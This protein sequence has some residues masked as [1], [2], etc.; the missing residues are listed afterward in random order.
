MNKNTVSTENSNTELQPDAQRKRHIHE[1]IDKK[2]GRWAKRGFAGG[3]GSTLLAL[4]VLAQATDEHLESYQFAEAIPGVRAAKLLPNGNVQLKLVD[5]RTVFVTAENV[6]ILDNG[7]IMLADEVVGEIAEF[8]VAAEAAGATATAGGVSGAGLALGGLGLAGA[9]AAAGGGG[10]GGGGDKDDSEV[11]PVTPSPPRPPSLNLQELQANELNNISSHSTTP[12]GTTSVEVTIGSITR[13]I[14]PDADGS[15]SVSLTSAEAAG[16]PQ[17]ISTVTIRHLEGSGTELSTETAQFDVDTVPPTLAITA[18]SAGTV[19]NTAERGENLEISGTTD[20][21]NGQIVAV[22]IGGRTYQG[23]VSGGGWSV[24]VPAA[25]LAALPDG[26]NVAVTADIADRAGNPADQATGAFDTDFSVPALTLNPVGGGSIDLADVG[27]DL[28][29][30][31]T[32]TAEN[33]QTVTVSFEG[34]NYVG[35][36]LGGNW[37]VTIPNADLSGLVTGTPASVSVVVNDAAG[38]PAAPVSASVPVDLTGPYIA[39]APLSVG[40]VLNAVEMGSNLMVS[41]TTGN[42]TDGQQV[43]IS[44][45]GQTYT[46]LVSNG[47]WGVTIPSADL[48]ALVDGGSFDLTADVTDADGLPAPQ[49][50]VNLTKDVSAPSLSIDSFSHGTVMNATERDADLTISGTTSAEGGQI[51]TVNLNGQ[52]YLGV[53]TGGSWAATVPASDLATLSDGATVVATADVSDLAGNPSA[54]ATGSFDTDFTPPALTISSLSSGPILNIAEQAS[55]LIVSGTSDVSNGTQVTV[56]IVDSNGAVLSSGTASVSGGAWTYTAAAADLSGLQDGASFDVN[57]SVSD[58]A[59]NA[60]STSTSFSTDLDAPT[61]AL[62]P[63]SVG[64]VL[65]VIEQGNDLSVSGTTSAD[66]GQTVTVSLNSMTYTS[67]V[68]GGSWNVVIPTA[69]LLGLADND[70]YQITASVQDVAGNPAINALATLG[71]NFQPILSLNTPGTNG[72]VSLSDAQNTG[73]TI[74]GGSAGLTGGQSVDVTLNSITIGSASVAADGSWSL[75]VPASAFAAIEAGDALGFSAQATVP[76]GSDPVPV[77]AEAFAHIPAAYTIVEAGRSGST[78]T[79]EIYADPDRDISSGLAFTAELGF[80]PLVATYD[81]GSESE[82]ADFNLFLANPSGASAISFAGAAT[83]YGDLS[84]PVVTFSMTIHDAAQPIVLTMTTPDGGPSQLHLGTSGADLL[85]GSNV[86][87]ILRGGEGDDIIDLSSAGRDV[88]VF[89]AD[90]ATNGVDSIR[91]FTLGQADDAS[92]AFMF[93]NLDTNTLRGDGTG[94][95][96]LMAGGAIGANTGFVGLATALADLDVNT[97]TSAAEN[98]SGAQAGDEIYLLATDGSDSLLVKVD[99]SNSNTA[100]VETLAQFDG[101]SDLSGLTS[102]NILMTDPTGA[103]A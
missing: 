70:N 21:E 28:V 54:Q 67:V 13:T 40:T 18:F 63:L 103:S 90:P 74:S 19:L 7:T 56:Q 61:I 62:N 50:S 41:G 22:T 17:G 78:V 97:V 101:L 64:P 42:V 5:G 24:T 66:D 73:L 77:S 86:D 4:P 30:T 33:G 72:A 11:P 31:G 27:G 92:D 32:T 26:A 47:N 89:E 65:D 6:Q 8:S 15:W 9:A 76:G 51:V 57:A 48:V 75:A 102:D 95:E 23:A 60:N 14:S 99:Y 3:L 34:Q 87:D 1:W 39:I 45:N 81:T 38:N 58:A 44:L 91:N 84:Q 43:T 59:G 37:S 29:L 20:A 69:D 12:E 82:N 93:Q 100:S 98:L 85:S 79:F 88:V 46:D 71:T 25:D 68:S 2:L 53:I 52:T 96:L 49:H 16:L 36:A 10:G 55:D 80:D 35:A 83:S 94:V